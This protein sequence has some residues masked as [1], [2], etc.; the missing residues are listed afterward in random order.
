MNKAQLKEAAKEIGITHYL[1]YKEILQRIFEVLK[2]KDAHYSFVQFAEDLGFSRSNVIWLVMSGRRKLTALTGQ[3][4]IAALGLSGV[5]RRYFT[6]LIKHNNTRDQGRRDKYVEQLL[7]FKRAELPSTHE[8]QQLEYYAEWY[9]PLLREMTGMQEF[10]ADPAWLASKIYGKLLPKEILGAL[11]LL[12]EL[13]LIEFD[14]E[15]QRFVQTGGQVRIHQLAGKMAAVCYHEKMLE[16]TK[17][18][19]TRVPA[20]RRDYNVLTLCVSDETAEQLK[21]LIHEFCERALALEKE[22]SASADQVF[23]LNVQLFPFTK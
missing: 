21:V 3:R 12:Q 5:D 11:D 17:E 19:I 7:A 4:V 16:I 1:D 20:E 6:T 15:N 13:G 2:N 22:K 10:R 23:Q 8:Q 18:S 14:E 9:Y